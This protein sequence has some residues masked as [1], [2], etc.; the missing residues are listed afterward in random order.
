MV[1]EE[2]LP[3]KFLVVCSEGWVPEL[4]GVESFFFLSVGVLV[5][6]ISVFHS[7]I[8]LDFIFEV[9]KPP[10]QHE[11]LV[12]RRWRVVHID[13]RRV[14]YMQHARY[15][16]GKIIFDYSGETYM[17]RTYFD[18]L[19]QLSKEFSVEHGVDAQDLEDVMY[20]FIDYLISFIEYQT[21]D[22][23][24]DSVELFKYRT[25]TGLDEVWD[26]LCNSRPL[27]EVSAQAL[28]EYYVLAEEQG[29]IYY[30]MYRLGFELWKACDGERD[31][32]L[33]EAVVPPIEGSQLKVSIALN[34]EN[35]LVLDVSSKYDS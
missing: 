22:G 35:K 2:A 1:F 32:S 17:T 3:P 13:A 29:R 5:V 11:T 4:A 12:E 31:L 27:A 14:A 9:V 21:P 33:E 7:F 19:R 26:H 16:L 28:K 6:V 25:F 30:D 10:P 20:S 15:L 34:S 8:V 18:D 23:T 24:I